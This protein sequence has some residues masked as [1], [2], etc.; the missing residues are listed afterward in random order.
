MGITSTTGLSQ[1]AYG[2]LVDEYGERIYKFCRRLAYSKEDAED[3]FQGVFL[4]ALEEPDKVAANP[5]GFLF[6]AVI[7]RWKSMKRKAARRNRIAP[8]APLDENTPGNFS[9][10]GIIL[11]HEESRIVRELVDAL[12]EK[13][14][15][16]MFMYYSAGMGLGDIATAMGLPVGTIKSRLH[17]G[18]KLVE[19]GLRDIGYES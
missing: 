8:A 12:P 3:L 17:K 18:R 10:E 6:S 13:F 2:A 9:M 14:K 4:K 5:Q 16:P 15:V 1:E 11:Q 19:K 7:Y